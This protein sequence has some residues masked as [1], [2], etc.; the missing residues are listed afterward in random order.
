MKQKLN[1]E[2]KIALCELYMEGWSIKDIGE[3][4]YIHPS[5]CYIIV[6]KYGHHVG[7]VRRPLGRPVGHKLSRDSRDKIAKTKTGSKHTE[8]TKDKISKSNKAFFKRK[9]SWTDDLFKYCRDIGARDWLKQ[10][11]VALDTTENCYAPWHLHN[12]WARMEFLVE[13]VDIFSHN[14]NPEV[15]LIRKE[16]GYE[17]E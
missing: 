3:A 13:D 2:D 16:E 6:R 5:Y 10:N 9:N 15:L 11:K 7:A 14:E 8:E 17:K 1:I 4:A 12:K